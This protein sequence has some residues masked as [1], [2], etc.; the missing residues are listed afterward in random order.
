MLWT[1]ILAQLTLWIAATNAFYP[2]FPQWLCD[3]DHVCNAQTSKRTTALGEGPSPEGG[4]TLKLTQ[5]IP[6]VSSI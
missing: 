5:R 1:I 2:Y 3:E 6:D 4:I